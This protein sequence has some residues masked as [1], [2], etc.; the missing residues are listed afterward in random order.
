MEA[1]HTLPGQEHHLKQMSWVRMTDPSLQ[2]FEV[3]YSAEEVV[4]RVLWQLE[5]A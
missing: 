2:G 3:S 1:E 4:L 5:L